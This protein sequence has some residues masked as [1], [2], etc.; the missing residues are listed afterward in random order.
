MRT[1]HTIH[2]ADSMKEEFWEKIPPRSVDLV[3]TSP[4]Y[5]MIEMWDN[6]FTQ[7]D[8]WGSFGK[9]RDR[10]AG[11]S[12]HLHAHNQLLDVWRPLIDRVVKPG[13]F[14]CIN[15]GDA[16]RTVGGVF[17]YY[18]NT[19][20]IYSFFGN[21]GAIATLPPILWH[22]PTNSPTKF[23]GSGMLPAGAYVTA[24]HEYILIFRLGGKREFGSSGEKLLR[25]Q[26]GY[27]W[28][29]RN[30]WFSDTWNIGGCRQSGEGRRTAAYPMEIPLRLIS[31]FSVFGDTVLDPFL[32]TGTTTWAAMASGRN[33]I[34]VEIDPDVVAA[35]SD[36][37]CSQHWWLERTSQH[38]DFVHHNEKQL[39]YENP[40]Y[41]KVKTA[42]ETDILIPRVEHLNHKPLESGREHTVTY[43][44]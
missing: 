26:S 7:Q 22:K 15:M 19:A 5:P 6:L 42:Q 38:R 34:G 33:S 17:K 40:Y 30:V 21:H 10:S 18:S 28:E 13:G 14:I 41:G 2:Y 12:M 37:L 29:E 43:T 11:H 3:V 9:A 44:L 24:E 27:F 25:R 39:K 16:T 23:M 20:K 1:T 4:P 8:R 32:G 31:M 35:P 36:T